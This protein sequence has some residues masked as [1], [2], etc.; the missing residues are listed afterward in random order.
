MEDIN[1]IDQEV[2]GNGDGYYDLEQQRISTY[3]KH[4]IQTLA[5]DNSYIEEEFTHRQHDES[6]GYSDKSNGYTKHDPST[7]RHSMPT[8]QDDTYG[9][10]T[11]NTRRRTIGA[12]SFMGGGTLRRRK[13]SSPFSDFQEPHF[14]VNVNFR[15]I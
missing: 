11:S 2:V 1:T 14:Q 12:R 15:Y 5:D 6:N 7:L 4:S 9:T 3:S 13:M 10:N 8:T